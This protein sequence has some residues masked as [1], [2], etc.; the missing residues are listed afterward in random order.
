M[1]RKVQISRDV[2]G[3]LLAMSR[4]LY[5]R[6]MIATLHGRYK[7]GVATIKEVYLAPSSIYGE[8]FSSFNPYAMPIDSSFIGVAHSHPSGYGTPSLEDLNHMLG[9]VM[10]IVTAPYRDERDIHVFDARGH[11]IEMEILDE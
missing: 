10:I 6:E 11:R 1:V 2:I 8:G 3:L 9:R 7:R 5:P 4:E